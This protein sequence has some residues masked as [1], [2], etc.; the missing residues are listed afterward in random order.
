M[1]YNELSKLKYQGSAQDSLAVA[2]RV[3]ENSWGP[4][5]H[6]M[7]ERFEGKGRPNL[8]DALKRQEL[9]GGDESLANTFASAGSLH[10]YQ[11][12]DAI[13]SEGGP[14]ND[15]YLVVAGTVA[16]VVKSN[17]IATRRAGQTIGE[18]AAIEPSQPRS[19][20]NLALETVVA[21]KVTGHEFD[22]IATAHPQIWKPL[23][24]EQARRLFE[25][26]KLIT[27]PNDAAKLFI[28]SS[29][30]GLDVA[31]AVQKGLDRDVLSTVWTDGVFFAGGYSLEALEKAVAGSDFAV[32]IA[33]PDDMIVSRGTSSP[34][35]RDNVLFELGLFMGKLTRYR[36]ILVHPRV[37]DLKLPSDLQGLSLL[38]YEPTPSV[39]ELPAR[40]G[41]VCT[42]IRTIV[43]NLG[44]Y[45]V[46]G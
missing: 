40:L 42:S 30:E 26:N 8:I 31:W 9:I 22:R 21:L 7:R 33:Q 5:R 14:D 18:M 6:V 28:I 41:T 2:A 24:R 38:S 46:I 27:A 39:T 32:A 10:E 12:G 11:K 35:V 13:I 45:K 15:V 3:N 25:R 34:T 20:S 19:A 36:T 29:A 37:K 23:A 17:H 44:V 4:W 43:R 1:P 16:V